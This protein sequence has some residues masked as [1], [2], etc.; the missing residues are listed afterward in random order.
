MN[1]RTESQRLFW[2]KIGMVSSG[3][4]PT[5]EQ[6]VVEINGVAMSFVVWSY[7]WWEVE[8]EKGNE[9]CVTM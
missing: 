7:R 2:Q 4:Y 5:N 8:M 6:V 9:A 1:W 3:K